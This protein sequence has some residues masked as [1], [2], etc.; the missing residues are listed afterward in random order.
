VLGD[1]ESTCLTIH[2]ENHRV[3]NILARF[4]L[5]TFSIGVANT[6]MKFANAMGCLLLT[7]ENKVI[8]PLLVALK[9]EIKL[10]HAYRF[11]KD[12]QDFI[13]DLGRS[14]YRDSQ[15]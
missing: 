7:D 9:A 6:V 14:G 15:S 1:L 3:G 4:D 5:R 11:V 10:S 12:P 8:S 2:K 13:A